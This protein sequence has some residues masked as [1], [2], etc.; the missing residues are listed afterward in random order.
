MEFTKED[1]EII[2][3]YLPKCELKDK[4]QLGLFA[5]KDTVN[6]IREVFH[7]VH[8]IWKSD[9]ENSYYA[10]FYVDEEDKAGELYEKSRSL[11]AL[12]ISPENNPN[13]KVRVLEVDILKK[14]T[15]DDWMYSGYE[16]IWKKDN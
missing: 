11:M 16:L 14:D 1:L 4:V 3:S 9:N 8:S 2:Y 7:D 6:C 12:K 15:E 10:K 5:H 13:A